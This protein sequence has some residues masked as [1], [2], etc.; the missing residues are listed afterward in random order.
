MRVYAHRN[1]HTHTK[2]AQTQIQTN[3]WSQNSGDNPENNVDGHKMTKLYKVGREVET[4]GQLR[5]TPI[6]F[7]FAEVLLCYA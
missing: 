6:G 1:T 3:R 4:I 7:M 2:H 5:S